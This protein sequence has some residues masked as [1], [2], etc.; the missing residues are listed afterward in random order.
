LKTARAISMMPP[1]AALS[2]PAAGFPTMHAEITGGEMTHIYKIV[3]AANWPA[4]GGVF[5]GA[6]VDLA[7]GFIHF[8]TAAQVE[9][10]AARHFRGQND[11]LLVAVDAEMLGSS[12]KWEVSRGGALFPHLYGALPLSAVAWARPLPLREDG[13]H[14]FSDL[15]S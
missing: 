7:D 5:R 12:L 15:A 8:S 9:E 4:E 6:G 14:D 10:T 11:P 2:R 1:P 13:G 3:A